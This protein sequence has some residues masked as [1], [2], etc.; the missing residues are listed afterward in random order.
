M[1]DDLKLEGTSLFLFPKHNILRVACATVV[2]F[3]HFDYCV[4]A[5]ILGSTI[6]LTLENP[7]D[8]PT[9]QKT[10]ALNYIDIS[11]TSL[12]GLECALKVIELGF[13]FNGPNSYIRNPWNM[14]DF[15]ILFMAI[16][17]SSQGSDEQLKVVKALRMVR[18]IKPL[19][20]I[21]RN[22][23][24]KLAVLSLLNSVGGILHVLIISA[25]FFLL[26]SIFG[27]NYFKGAFFSCQLEVGLD[28]YGQLLLAEEKNIITVWDCLN[29]G[30]LWSNKVTSFDN[31]FRASLTLFEMSTTESWV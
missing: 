28:Y 11:F 18:V 12:F 22:E 6:S 17:S 14:M 30:G 31:V 1:K 8:D 20:V 15:F 16:M 21:S 5:V 24:L 29:E 10:R 13:L 4:L 19:R 27:I 7:L 3:K 26:F 25:M 23:G 2:N 9:G